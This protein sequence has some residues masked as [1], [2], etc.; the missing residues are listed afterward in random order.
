MGVAADLGIAPLRVSPLARVNQ[1]FASSTVGAPILSRTMPALDA[2]TLR[3][4]R[5]RTTYTEG[6]AGLPTIY[7]TTRGARTGARR[8]VPLLAVV[9]GDD[10]AVIGSIWGRAR[11]PG[12][13]HNL[14]AD[15]HATVTR[16][17]R[18][19][20]VV[21]REVTGPEA[22]R[23]WAAARALYRG[24]RTYPGRTHGR[25]IRVFLLTAPAA[26]GS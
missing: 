22:D 10:L 13:V 3:L 24:Y 7:V 26:G 15:P 17:D 19:L 23:I 14:L 18:R 8:T 11:H 5:G 9:S 21:A 16:H 20:E 2:L 25:T 4:T 1:W 12:W 6:V